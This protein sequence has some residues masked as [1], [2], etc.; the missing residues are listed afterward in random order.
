LRRVIADPLV[1]IE[2]VEADEPTAE[3]A[4][5]NAAWQLISRA[6]AQAYP[7]VGTLPYLTTAATDGRHWHRFTDDVY[8][9]AP[10]AMDAAQRASVHG[11]NEHLSIDSLRRGE[12]F[13]RALLRGLGAGEGTD[14]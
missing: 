13:Y 6:V 11:V 2:V 8:R 10:L 5:G 4:T 12:R 14:E 1:Q 9:F 3:A 7:G